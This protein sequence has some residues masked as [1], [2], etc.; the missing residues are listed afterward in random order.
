MPSRATEEFMRTLQRIE[1]SRD[2]G[3]LVEMFADDAELASP[4]RDAT[5]RGR[6]GA[7]TFWEEYL[8]AFSRVQSTFTR[9]REGDGFAV[10]EWVS[11]GALANN[12]PIRYPGVSILE[13]EGDRVTR[14]STYYDSA[15]FLPQG[16]KRAGGRPAGSGSDAGEGKQQE[17]EGAPP[18]TGSPRVEGM[19]SKKDSGML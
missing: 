9:V 7:R 18:R 15:A 1:Q 11:D 12:D 6:D 19:E 16:A 8:S 2:V 10:L 3:P 17:W 13:L 5:R 14:F 4:E